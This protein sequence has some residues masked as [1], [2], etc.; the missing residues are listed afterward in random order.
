[1][2]GTQHALTHMTHRVVIFAIA[3]ISCSSSKVTRYPSSAQWRRGAALPFSKFDPVPV[4][5]FPSYRQNSSVGKT[6]LLI[7]H[8]RIQDAVL[9]HGLGGPRDAAVNFNT[10]RILQQHRA[11]SLPQHGFLVGLCTLQLSDKKW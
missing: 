6:N 3:Q 11:V 5:K 8:W 1:M 4:G 10:Y 7:V 2:R 9:S